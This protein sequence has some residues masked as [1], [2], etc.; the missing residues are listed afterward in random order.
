MSNLSSGGR[1]RT[2]CKGRTPLAVGDDADSSCVGSGIPLASQGLI[3]STSGEVLE[4]KNEVKIIWSDSKFHYHFVLCTCISPWIGLVSL[5]PDRGS[6]PDSV[7]GERNRIPSSGLGDGLRSLK[8]EKDRKKIALFTRKGTSQ[9]NR[10]MLIVLQEW[11]HIFK[12]MN[13]QFSSSI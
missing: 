12:Q 6:S 3:A 2:Q 7:S 4:T 10:V 8:R 13:E 11:Y 1:T 5:W 9:S